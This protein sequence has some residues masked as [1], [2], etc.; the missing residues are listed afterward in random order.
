MS[1]HQTLKDQARS[2][3]RSLLA[4]SQSFRNLEREE[5]MALYKD[6][7]DAHYNDFAE[8]SG[9]ATEMAVAGD[10]INEERHRNER[11]GKAGQTTADILSDT[12]KKVDFPGF[13]KDLLNGVFDANLNANIKQMEAFQNLLKGATQSLSQFVNAI[14]DDEAMLRLVETNNQY[15]LKIVQAQQ[16]QDGKRSRSSRRTTQGGANQAGANQAGANQAGTN[17]AGTNQGEERR[18]VLL[19][20]NG[21]EVNMNDNA[22]QAKILDAKLAMAKERR[23]MLR[24]T[25][26]MGVSRLVVEKGTIRA[27]VNFTINADEVTTNKDTANVDQT[28]AFSAG[29]SAGIFG[30]PSGSFSHST[31]KITVASSETTKGTDSTTEMEGFVEIQF[32]SDYFKLDNFRETFDL[33][34]GQVAQV[35]AGAAQQPQLQ[36]QAAPAAP[37]QTAPQ[38]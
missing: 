3:T 20:Q 4:F 7:V 1:D 2:K 23:T 18:S 19:D 25:I 36:P 22:I 31:S 29:W 30:G 11:V 24:E 16:S 35:P 9:L 33:G 6:L 12:V 27:K 32:K 13:V 17:Q 26:L 21:K 28:N 10:L 8:Q 5:Q 34:Q 15:K 38:V 14:K 37:V